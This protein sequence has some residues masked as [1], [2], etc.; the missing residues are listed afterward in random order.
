MTP[1]ADTRRRQI[2]L[3]LSA[4]WVLLTLLWCVPAL[5]HANLVGSSPSVGSKLSASPPQVRL[6]FSEPVDA[7]FSPLEVRDEDGERVDEDD[8]RIDPEDARVVV[9]NLEELPKGSYLVEWRVTSLDGHVVEGRYEFAVAEG[10]E[11]KPPGDN[12]G[13]E[14]QGDEAD[15]GQAGREQGAQDRTR[16]G[17]VSIV[18][19]SALSFGA[20]AVVVVGALLVSR[21]ARR[22]KQ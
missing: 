2:L 4:A 18:A 19:Y 5:A 21:L 8:A 22:P 6:R 15:A 1:R 10:G 3:W 17:S 20:L 11:G 7:E 9:A 12:P 16:G 14:G 13:V